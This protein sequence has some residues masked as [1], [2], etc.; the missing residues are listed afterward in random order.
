LREFKVSRVDV[1][2]SFP[3]SIIM[4]SFFEEGD[5][6]KNRAPIRAYV[7]ECQ[8]YQWIGDPWRWAGD[9]WKWGILGRT[10]AAREISS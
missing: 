8:Y 10:C 5:S 3:I 2:K 9:A 4:E 1:G 6:W 7:P